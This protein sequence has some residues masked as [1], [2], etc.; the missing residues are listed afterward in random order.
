MGV[1]DWT[2]CI[3]G[4]QYTNLARSHPRNFQ[5]SDVSSFQ[6]SESHHSHPIASSAQSCHCDTYMEAGELMNLSQKRHGGNIFCI[7]ER[8]SLHLVY[9]LGQG[10]ILG[11]LQRLQTTFYSSEG[12]RGEKYSHPS[13]VIPAWPRVSLTRPPSLMGA[14]VRVAFGFKYWLAQGLAA[15]C[16]TELHCA[17]VSRSQNM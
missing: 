1:G 15:I 11:P 16:W 7:L 8:E 5:F 17:A 6:S 10:I 3:L 2:Q 14:V 9:T 12:R 13:S 4:K